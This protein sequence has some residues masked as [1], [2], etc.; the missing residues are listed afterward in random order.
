[1]N[2]LPIYGRSEL[3]IR[4]ALAFFVKSV[5]L[6]PAPFSVVDWLRSLSEK[7]FKRLVN[8][9]DRRNS[10]SFFLLL[11]LATTICSASETILP[12]DYEKRCTQILG[13]SHTFV[14][15]KTKLPNPKINPRSVRSRWCLSDDQKHLK[16][17]C[18]LWWCVFFAACPFSGF[19]IAIRGFDR[20]LSGSLR[21]LESNY[22]LL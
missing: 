9:N 7:D 17:T 3:P 6:Y 22:H 4:K 14:G 18:S 2:Q 15:W 11:L 19:L 1:M 13:Y 5:R 8:Y 10:E 12:S 21:P 16:K 20:H